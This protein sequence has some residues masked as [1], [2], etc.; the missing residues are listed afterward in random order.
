MGFFD[1]EVTNLTKKG[2]EKKIGKSIEGDHLEKTSMST[3]TSLNWERMTCH[4]DD[5]QV[6]GLV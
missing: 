4:Y 5:P 2:V 6:W 1:W 3:S